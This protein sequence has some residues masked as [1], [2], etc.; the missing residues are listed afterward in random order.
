MS[1]AMIICITVIVCLSVVCIC[2]L[3]AFT[4]AM[5]FKS[6]EVRESRIYMQ[7]LLYQMYYHIDHWVDKMCNIE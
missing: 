7:N 6:R 4:A 2:G 5:K 3:S 1:T